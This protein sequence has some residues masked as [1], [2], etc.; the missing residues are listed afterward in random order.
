[1]SIRNKRLLRTLIA[2]AITVASV[3]SVAVVSLGSQASAA[4]GRDERATFVDGWGQRLD[5]EVHLPPSHRPGTSLP[6]VVALHGCGMT[7]YEDNSMKA[8]T[9][10]NDLADARGFIVVYPT[11]NRF[12]NAKG[13]WNGLV[14]GNQKRGSGEPSLLA[15]VTQA[16]VANYGADAKRVYAV[17]ASAGAAMT[18]VLGVTYPDVYAAIGS[19][20][21]G[22]Y[23]ADRV[24]LA[25]VDNVSPVDTAK[26]AYAQMGP[27]ARQVPT[28]VMHGTEDTTVKPIFGDR[29]VTHWAAIDDLANDGRLDGDVDDVPDSVQRVANPGEHPY[30]K[31]V[32]TDATTQDRLIEKYVVEGLAHKWPG[33]GEGDYVDQVGPNLSTLVWDFFS[34]RSL[35]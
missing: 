3:T 7:G 16:V 25:G 32:Y 9:R 2:A 18:V 34:G 26:L 24:L 15:G 14:P 23:A 31:T 6:V 29:L 19:L 12:W 22:E 17:G 5:Y 1:M 27:R 8:M 30:V 11:Q 13:C 35:P 10:F 20:A 33:G 21:G 28:F 4:G